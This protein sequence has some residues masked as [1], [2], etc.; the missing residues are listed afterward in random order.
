MNKA[1]QTAWEWLSETEQ[2]SLFLTL[3]TGKSSWE[4]GEMLKISHYKYL[5]IKE[6]SEVF[7]KLFTSFLEKHEALFRPDGPC[8][9]DFK[10]YMEAVI[11]KRKTRKEA[12][13]FSG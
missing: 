8:Q 13:L 6:R 10:D 3:S 4:A 9:E 12:A 7:F 2:R 11:C 5:E 1:Q